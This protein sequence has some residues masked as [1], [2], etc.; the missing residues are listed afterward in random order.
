MKDQHFK[1][2]WRRPGGVF[3]ILIIVFSFLNI[4]KAKAIVPVFDAAL[5]AQLAISQG[6]I[7]ANQLVQTKILTGIA[8]GEAGQY[9]KEIGIPPP[10]LLPYLSPTIGAAAVTCTNLDCF[11]WILAKMAV[12][13]LSQQIISWIRTGNW[14]DGPLFVT[15]WESFLLGAIDQASGKFLEELNLTQL[16][17]PFSL[18]IRLGL[19]N[20]IVG[21]GGR[22]I[23][24]N[25]RAK[26]TISDA[27]NNLQNFYND[28]ANG[29]WERWIQVSQEPSNN[30]YMSFLMGIEALE[31]RRQIASEKNFF[32]AMASQGLLGQKNCRPATQ[33]TEAGDVPLGE[34]CDIVTPGKAVE[35]ELAKVLG[36]NIDQLNLADEIDEIL[37]A[38]LQTMLQTIINSAQVLLNT[39][40]T[41]TPTP[42]PT[43]LFIPTGGPIPTGVTLPTTS[44]TPPVISP[45]P[46]PIMAN[47]LGITGEDKVG[48]T[49][50]GPS[51][52]ADYHIRVTDLTSI[53]VRVTISNSDSGFWETPFTGNA[54]L[55]AE[56]DGA[57]NADLWLEPIGSIP[58]LV[59]IYYANGPIVSATITP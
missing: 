2:K 37:M 13:T 10:L 49:S 24:Y 57:G 28:F 21:R 53:P 8:Q 34:I 15:D 11:A 25:M 9:E 32:E 40:L 29:G 23:P 7:I 59:T 38:L 16:C 6:T 48:F 46:N 43:P 18:Q 39:A 19:S 14:D 35:E 5:S 31:T 20:G 3:L 33:E 4:P 30:P 55:L 12:H 47:Y 36:V 1:I 50:V 44:P 27:I 45:T 54:I 26:C 17:A 52:I 42:I 58:T 56:Y 41:D 22:G 51:G